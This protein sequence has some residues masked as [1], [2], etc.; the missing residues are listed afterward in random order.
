MFSPRRKKVVQSKKEKRCSVQE[1]KKLFSLRRKKVV[2]S[3]KEK[4]K[5]FSPRRKKSCSGQEGKKVVQSKKEKKL[6]SPRRGEKVVQSK[7]EKKLFSPR[8]KKKLFSPRSSRYSANPC[9][10]ASRAKQF[11]QQSVHQAYTATTC[12]NIRKFCKL[13]TD[14]SKGYCMVPHTTD[15]CYFTNQH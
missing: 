15:K 5:L 2:Q 1:G 11:S 9:L 14:C 6:F 8:R 13:S 4:K 7:K 12:L 3:K 10:I